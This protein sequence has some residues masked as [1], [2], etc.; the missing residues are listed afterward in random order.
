MRHSSSYS[1][2]NPNPREIAQ[3]LSSQIGSLVLAI[4]P[5]GNR[6]RNEWKVGSVQGEP[7][8][9]LS[10]HLSGAKAGIWADFSAD[11]RGDALD[12][13]AACCCAGN[14]SEACK[15]ACDWLG[16]SNNGLSSSSR[17]VPVQRVSEEDIKKRE[18]KE[19]EDKKKRILAARAMWLSAKPLTG[20]CPASLYL[21]HRGINLKEFHHIPHA[22]R[23]RDDCWC[24]ETQCE[25][26]ALVSAMFLPTGQHV[27]TH[28]TYLERDASGHWIKAKLKSAKKILGPFGGSFI[29]LQKGSSGKTL[30]K[31]APNEILMIGEG[32]ETSLSVAWA[33]PN[34]RVLAAGSLGNL[35]SIQ[36]SE[37]I[38]RIIILA[39]NDENE[40]AKKT[41]LRAAEKLSNGGKRRISACWSSKGKDFNDILSAR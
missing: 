38:G 14:M 35:G 6:Y 32:I 10:V 20:N 28:R 36:F 16:W 15:W 24:S 41:L 19:A 26:P 9:S 30:S 12:L 39:D 4:L 3:A 33:F 21:R 8:N 29:P 2:D 5:A 18:Q 37:N 13:V 31:A 22:L 40:Q 7:G 17:S 25:T 1:F 27:A 23:F 11:M 34:I